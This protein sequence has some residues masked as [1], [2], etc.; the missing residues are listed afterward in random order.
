MLARQGTPDQQVRGRFPPHGAPYPVPKGELTRDAIDRREPPGHAHPVSPV[1]D[2]HGTRLCAEW[3]GGALHTRLE[4][5]DAIRAAQRDFAEDLFER[6]SLEA[7]HHRFGHVQRAVREQPNHGVVSLRG[8]GLCENGSGR[9][10][11]GD[12]NSRQ[13]N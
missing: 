12:E 7:E 1:P 9:E 4:H 5:L 6:P 13:Q 3:Q 2:L 8:I 10:Q 11:A